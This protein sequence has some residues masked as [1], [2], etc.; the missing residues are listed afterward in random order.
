MATGSDVALAR[1]SEIAY[2]G[3]PTSLP[4][5]FFPVSAAELPLPAGAGD[6][7]NEGL[8]RNSNAAALVV[9]GRLNGK[10]T[11][12]LAF[13]GS[14]DRQDSI[15]DLQNINNEFPLFANLIRAF[16]QYVARENISQVAVTGHSLGGAMAQIYM[17]THADTGS[18]QY[19]S[20]T[21]GSPGALIGAGTD[22]RITNFR[23]ADDPAV[24]LGE[25]RAAV[26]AELRSNPAEAGA[27]VFVA[28]E[29]FPGL[30]ASDAA[31]ALPSLT[32]DYVNRGTNVTLPAANGST[33]PLASFNDAANADVM[34]HKIP[35]YIGRLSAATGSTGDDQVGPSIT[36]TTVG[37]PVFRFFDKTNGTH[38]FTASQS[39]RD[40]IVSSRADL[41]LEG[42]GLNSLNASTQPSG[43]TAVFRFFDSIHGTHFYTASQAEKD[44]VA[45]TRAD[46]KFE[47]VGFYEHT[48]AQTGDTA[49]YRFFDTTFG[50][51]FYTPNATEAASIVANR[52]DLVQE[53]VAFYTSVA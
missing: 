48:T 18:V 2:L 38:F 10:L 46:L 15:N 47:G 30:T 3:V 35:T 24:F 19:V 50:T 5:G 20:D 11:A 34:E 25:H 40:A 32:Q 21:F 44:A 9:I 17:S 27:A 12:V 16:D 6:A 37:L 29:V 43:A 7:F 51:H 45:A 13:R 1:I 23:I 52:T 33:T 8:Y 49:V 4:A 42:V 39:E 14:D 53:G 36:P 41:Q 31:A 26:G 28:P 22:A